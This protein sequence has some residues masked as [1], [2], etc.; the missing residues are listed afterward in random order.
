MANFNKILVA[1]FIFAVAFN[2][3]LV[4]ANFS[5]GMYLTWGV[6]HAAIQGNGEDLQLVLD[7]FSGETSMFSIDKHTAFFNMLQMNITIRLRISLNP[8][9]SN[10][11]AKE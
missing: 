3:F 8:K 6:Q 11:S 10:T 2:F 9:A 1:S 5:K 7:R 4:D